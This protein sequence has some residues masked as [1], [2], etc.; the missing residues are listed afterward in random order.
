M[1]RILNVSASVKVSDHTNSDPEITVKNLTVKTP[2]LIVAAIIGL[3]LLTACTPR[4]PGASFCMGD[5]CKVCSGWDCYNSYINKDHPRPKSPES[6]EA[7]TQ[8]YQNV[9]EV[10]RDQAKGY[11][12]LTV[13]L[14][15]GRTF[16]KASCRLNKLP[17]YSAL[18]ETDNNCF[19][20]SEE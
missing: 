6:R 13:A 9:D 19:K 16:L 18:L 11:S 8:C 7:V 10:T 12:S 15:G 5:N 20:S 1:T 4:V 14:R 3:F 2:I 17:R